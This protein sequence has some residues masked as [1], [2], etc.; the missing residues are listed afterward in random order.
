LIIDTPCHYAIIY[1]FDAIDASWLLPLIIDT[2]FR[3]SAPLALLID[4]H[5]YFA[6]D[7]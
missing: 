4:C 5:Y 2:P 3:F 7:F 6:I 1:Y